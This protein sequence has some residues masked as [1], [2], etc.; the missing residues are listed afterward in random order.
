MTGG[1]SIGIVKGSEVRIELL[2]LRSVVYIF[3]L[4]SMD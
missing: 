2:I 4:E 3:T 1:C